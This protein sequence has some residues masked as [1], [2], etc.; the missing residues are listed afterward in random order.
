MLMF[1]YRITC[2]HIAKS[3]WSGLVGILE[4][5]GAFYLY[6]AGHKPELLDPSVSHKPHDICLKSTVTF[7][8]EDQE[9]TTLEPVGCRL[10]SEGKG[11]GLL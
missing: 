3:A 4:Q 9:R 5:L 10:R 11:S 6:F 8:N 2:T 7:V 1:G